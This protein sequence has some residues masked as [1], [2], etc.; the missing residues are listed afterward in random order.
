MVVGFGWAG[1]QLV[2]PTHEELSFDNQVATLREARV[3]IG[4]HGG[5]MSNTVFC[6]AGTRVGE[7]FAEEYIA[8][9]FW[10]L[11]NITG[12]EH[13]YMIGAAEP[14]AEL[15]EAW[16]SGASMHVDLAKLELF[17]DRLLA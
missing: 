13:H 14:R 7:I 2:A 9:W 16:N 11:A 1:P 3:V 10:F 15:A 12:V 8:S 4:P 17:V 5:G 6:A